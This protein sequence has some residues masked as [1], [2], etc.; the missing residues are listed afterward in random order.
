MISDTRRVTRT[1]HVERI[2]EKRNMK[3]RGHLNVYAEL[4]G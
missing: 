3:K 1:V 4:G 2:G